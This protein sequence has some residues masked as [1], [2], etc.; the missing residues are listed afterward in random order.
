M[1]KINGFTLKELLVTIVLL[2]IP[3][4]TRVPSIMNVI[5]NSRLT[6][7][8]KAPVSAVQITRSISV[9]RQGHT[10]VSSIASP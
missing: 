10:G 1:G 2:M 5:R 3:G 7:Q 9:T 8:T 6:T 4:A